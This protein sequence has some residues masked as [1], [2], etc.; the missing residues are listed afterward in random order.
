[1]SD[2]RTTQAVKEDGGDRGWVPVRS[3]DIHNPWLLMSSVVMVHQQ[4]GHTFDRYFGEC[5]TNSCDICTAGTSHV[6]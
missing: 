6:G 5:A 4:S 3:V 1:M 2:C